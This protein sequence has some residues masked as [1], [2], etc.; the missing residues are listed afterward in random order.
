MPPL[1]LTVSCR[2][3]W[4]LMTLL[5][6]LDSQT[7][8]SKILDSHRHLCGGRA[9]RRQTQPQ[10]NFRH[11]GHALS[12]RGLVPLFISAALF[13]SPPFTSSTRP[14]F[15]STNARNKSLILSAGP[16][17]FF[18]N[19]S[20]KPLI[21][22]FFAFFAFLTCTAASLAAFLSAVFAVVSGSRSAFSSRF[23][24][25]MARISSAA[26]SRARVMLRS[27]SHV[28]AGPAPP[29]MSQ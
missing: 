27:C 24:A 4:L 22:A 7:N 29:S 19:S 20:C 5:L 9:P 2:R 18:L 13:T 23:V 11:H 12:L 25:L 28:G 26:S 14:V 6:F 1:P 21:S 15:F 3:T 16:G 10:P 17:N 8:S